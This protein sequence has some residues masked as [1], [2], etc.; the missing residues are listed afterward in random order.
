MLPLDSVVNQPSQSNTGEVK[1]I[2]R[3]A[4][5]IDGK[6][7]SNIVIQDVEELFLSETEGLPVDDL[8]AVVEETTLPQNNEDYGLMNNQKKLESG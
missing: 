3:L 2:M 7:F 8:V 4:H 5:K 1:Q 6:G